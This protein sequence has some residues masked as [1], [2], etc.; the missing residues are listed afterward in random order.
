MQQPVLSVFDAK[1]GLYDPPFIVR[2]QGEAMRQFGILKE[3]QET[4]YG[5]TPSDFILRQIA[6]FDDETG[7]FTNVQAMDLS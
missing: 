3:N 7:V 1:T 4:K 2:H 6:T 5:K